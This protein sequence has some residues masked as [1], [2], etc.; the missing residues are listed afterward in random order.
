MYSSNI[1]EQ[2]CSHSVDE[3]P[4]ECCGVILESGTSGEQTVLRCKNNQ[5]EIH[6]SDPE[7]NPRDAHTAYSISPADLLKIDRMTRKEDYKLKAVYHSHPDTKAY[8]S[9]EDYSFATFNDEPTHPGTD[10]IIVSIVK[11][12]VEETVCF[13]WDSKSKRFSGRTINVSY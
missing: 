9:K 8:F 13:F 3:Y 10:Y 11:K 4:F 2:I 5:N 12:R 1:V 7:K 6:K